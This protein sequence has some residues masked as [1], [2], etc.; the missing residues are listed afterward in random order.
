M[1]TFH[2]LGKQGSGQKQISVPFAFI[3]IGDAV[4]AENQQTPISPRTSMRR[5]KR[6]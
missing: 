6:S 5:I 1:K 3:S 4:V 2:A